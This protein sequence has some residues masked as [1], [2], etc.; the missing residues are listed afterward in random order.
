MNLKQSS[1][2]IGKSTAY[3]S[4]LKKTSPSVFRFQ[5]KYGKGNLISGYNKYIQYV[6][7]LSRQ[8]EEIYYSFKTESEFARWLYQNEI[9]SSKDVGTVMARAIFMPIEKVNIKRIKKFKKI[10][11]TYKKNML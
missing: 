11:R 10:I 9:C 3:Y 7:N 5:V 8:V 4:V 2:D 6:D 1:L